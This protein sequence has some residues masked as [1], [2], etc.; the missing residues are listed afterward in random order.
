MKYV[1]GHSKDLNERNNLVL[2]IGYN[3]KFTVRY[4]YSKN[5]PWRG[6]RLY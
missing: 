5:M 3:V 6:N 2:I 4:Y 1:I